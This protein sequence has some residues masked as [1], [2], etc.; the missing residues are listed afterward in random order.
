MIDYTFFSPNTIYRL[1]DRVLNYTQDY[2][3]VC[4][5]ECIASEFVG[6]TLIPYSYAPQRNKIY[7]WKQLCCENSTLEHPSELYYCDI[8]TGKQIGRASCRERVSSPV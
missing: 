4:L 6:D 1:G 8:V 3:Q 7:Y 5:W 2:T